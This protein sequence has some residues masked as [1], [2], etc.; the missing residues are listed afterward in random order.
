MSGI[1]KSPPSDSP[2]HKQLATE[3]PCS[4]SAPLFPSRS[5]VAATAQHRKVAGDHDQRDG[6][7]GGA[8]SKLEPPAVAKDRIKKPKSS[9]G[10]ET[11][12]PPKLEDLEFELII[13]QR[14]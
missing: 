5:T 14:A 11:Q 2:L 10:R 8:P 6:Q 13:S 4:A 3:W 12:I 9:S 1:V 7:P